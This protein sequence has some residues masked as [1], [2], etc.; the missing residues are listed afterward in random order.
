MKAGRETE[1]FVFEVEHVGLDVDFYHD[2]GR[3]L[4][5]DESVVEAFEAQREDAEIFTQSTTGTHFSCDEML[6]WFLLQT[7]TTVADHLPAQPSDLEGKQVMLTVPIRF[8]PGMFHMATEAGDV[9]LCAL[10]LMCKV[11]TKPR[12]G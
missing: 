2:Q 10:K 5:L 12:N 3:S 6:N 8:K 11:T 9:D 4:K 7:D 1:D